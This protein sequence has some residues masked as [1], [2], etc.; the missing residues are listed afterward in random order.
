MR[1]GRIDLNSD[2][3]VVSVTFGCAG[4]TIEK[5]SCML[6]NSTYFCAV[7]EIPKPTAQIPTAKMTARMASSIAVA[8]RPDPDPDPVPDLVPA[9]C[10]CRSVASE[11]R[12]D[13]ASDSGS[14]YRSHRASVPTAGRSRAQ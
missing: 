6:L 11:S 5:R 7:D 1:E 8:P 4:K 13:R 3:Y 10:P 9:R 14:R 2:V 12:C